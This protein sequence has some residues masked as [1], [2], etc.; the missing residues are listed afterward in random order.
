MAVPG[1]RLL[2]LKGLSPAGHITKLM[3][4]PPLHGTFWRP[5]LS[6]D[7]RR[8]LVSFHP[9]NEK[10]FHIYE[11]NIDGSGL[12]QITDGIYDDVDPIYLADDKNIVF[13]ST[14]GHNY[15][16]CMPPTN[17]FV[18]SRCDLDGRNMY[19]ISRNNEPDF[20]PAVMNDGR[21]LYTRWEYTDKGLW[22]IQS[23]WTTN[24]DGTGTTVFWGNQSVWP[25]HVTEARAIPG[26]DKVMFNGVGHHQWFCGSIGIILLA[27]DGLSFLC[28][29]YS[30]F[31]LKTHYSF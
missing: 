29:N 17:S 11:I 1:G 5:D 12:R 22:R 26:S 31:L 20:L 16:R 6:F 7:A 10:N 27:L 24:P 13:A 4:Q 2:T 28:Q 21:I 9:A 25:D 3:P 23:L 18:L 8:V 19:I 14:R 30:Y 15:V